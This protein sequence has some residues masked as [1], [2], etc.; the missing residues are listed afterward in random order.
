MFHYGSMPFDMNTA[1]TATPLRE[2][3]LPDAERDPCAVRGTVRL[4]TRD[5]RDKP[6]VDPRYFTTSTTRVMTRGLRVARGSRR[7]PR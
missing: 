7:R 6:K 2:R 3:L 1:G 5:Y 4:R